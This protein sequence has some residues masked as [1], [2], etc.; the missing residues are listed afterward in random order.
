MTGFE[1]S[2]SQLQG[3]ENDDQAEDS[4]PLYGCCEE[5]DRLELN[6]QNR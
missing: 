2:Q 4:A 3:N 5:R 1:G 6:M